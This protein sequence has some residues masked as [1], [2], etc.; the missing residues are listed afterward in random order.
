M[1]FVVR[2]YAKG[3]YQNWGIFWAYVFC[4]LNTLG[5]SVCVNCRIL[6]VLM[7]SP[8]WLVNL[9]GTHLIVNCSGNFIAV[10]VWLLSGL[11]DKCLCSL[12]TLTQ[13][14]SHSQLV[15]LNTKTFVFVSDLN[16][17]IGKSTMRFLFAVFNFITEVQTVSFNFR[18]FAFINN[19]PCWN[20]SLWANVIGQL[21]VQ[22]SPDQVCIIIEL[23]HA[24]RRANKRFIVEFRC[25]IGVFQQ[26]LSV[27]HWHYLKWVAKVMV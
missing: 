6:W 3:L 1:C 8:K 2:V 17:R 12:H 20:Y 13:S 25:V 22:L 11:M 16:C 7:N 9:Q 4:C 14:N 26:M 21:A 24:Q 10:V 19:K 15:H 18:I 27:Y 23:V 5:L